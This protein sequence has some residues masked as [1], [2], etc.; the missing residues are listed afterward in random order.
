MISA[1][2]PF[3]LAWRTRRVLAL[4]VVLLGIG[5]AR[6]RTFRAL[7]SF[8]GPPDGY[9]PSPGLVRDSAGNIYGTTASGGAYNF[10]GTVFK[11]DKRGNETVLH[12]FCSGGW[13]CSDGAYPDGGLVRGRDGYLYGT[14]QVGGY[15]NCS[16]GYGC[17]TI[18]K[19]DR[20]GNFSVLYRFGGLPDGS[21]PVSTLVLDDQQNLYGTTEYGGDSHCDVSG[22]CGTV[23]KVD[24]NGKETILHAFHGA[25]Q[26]DGA[27]P[28]AGL[29]WSHAGRL[30]GTT[31]A[32]GSPG[33]D[34]WMDNGCGIVFRVN[35][36][37]RETVLYRFSPSGTTG[38]RPFYP[39][40][41][42]NAGNIYST[43]QGVAFRLN[44]R[45]QVKILCNFFPTEDGI[46][47]DGMAWG[48]KGALYGTTF[49]GGVDY[50]GTVYRL[51]RAGKKTILY[52][53]T[54]FS[55]GDYPLGKLVIDGD[56]NLYGVTAD[57]GITNTR[58]CRDGCGV[59]FRIAP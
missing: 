54:G 33:C 49:E 18:F 32:G 53:F 26:M 23:F 39:V 42:D 44:R 35:K 46:P 36:V 13:P 50:S 58:Y 11:I 21:F 22:G 29:V 41:L 2:R 28:W 5:A 38:M 17:G 51:D 8:K 14:T 25:T 20:E 37:G 56:G 55:D 30:I 47:S 10:Y 16:Y 34:G 45:G 12:S 27:I 1:K 40:T 3:P 31:P 15:P 4:L 6:A 9:D 57:G 48:G 7:Y 59:V 52:N 19:I 43:A 24:K